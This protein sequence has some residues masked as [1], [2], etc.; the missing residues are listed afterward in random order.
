VRTSGEHLIDVLEG[1]RLV[2]FRRQ[3][4]LPRAT[5]LR[6]S[7]E[8]EG[9]GRGGRPRE[10]LIWW[11][12][13]GGVPL[14]RA[15]G[16]R[17]WKRRNRRRGLAGVDCPSVDGL[18]VGCCCCLRPRGPTTRAPEAHGYM[19]QVH[20]FQLSRFTLSKISQ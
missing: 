15:V 19:S 13:G 4:S 7:G 20:C 14:A 16:W 9:S 5:A 3:R 10:G 1:A 11:G 12:A 17:L 2:H 8:V 18:R 6:G